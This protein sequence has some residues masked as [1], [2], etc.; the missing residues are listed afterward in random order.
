MSKFNAPFWRI[1]HLQESQN[2]AT[3]G[4]YRSR[5]TLVLSNLFKETEVI[6]DKPYIPRN[7]Y[8]PGFV[9]KFKLGFVMRN[10]LKLLTIFSGALLIGGC[11]DR[12]FYSG[13]EN[14]TTTAQSGSTTTPVSMFYDYVAYATGSWPESVAIGDVN[15]DGLN[16]IVLSTSYYFDTP[17]DYKIHV[18]LQAADGTLQ[19]RVIYD[20]GNGKSVDIGDVNG[21]GLKDVVV[22]GNVSFGVLYQNTSGTLD[23][24]TTYAATNDILRVRIGDFNNDNLMDVA[25]IAW[26]STTDATTQV[27]DVYLQQAAGTLGSAN[28]Y[29]VV[30]AGYD[31]L[32]V[33]DL[34]ND[35]LTDLVVMSGQGLVDNFGVLLQNNTGT[36]DGAVYYNLGTTDLTHGIAI[37][38]VNGD[39]FQDVVVTYGGNSPSANIGIF[40]QNTSNTLD[41]VS[42]LS[43]YDIPEPV[44]IADVTQDGRADVIVAHGGWNEVGVYVQGSDGLL[45]AEQLSAIPYASH[46]NPHGLAVGDINNDGKNDVVIADYNNGL[47]V[48]VKK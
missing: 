29:S 17:N 27:V 19:S 11:Y 33:G 40:L 45:Q 18:F 38:D 34:N 10:S 5:R 22:S 31:D 1:I 4:I 20:A 24:M 39:S 8:K 25:T 46:Y 7:S 9:L 28:S 6:D 41:P 30:H 2:I 42:S 3:E 47:V 16:D 26:G 14:T 12:P 23:A 15:G 48:L 36:M 32:K 44:V 35:G 13:T 21:D 43:S 37:G